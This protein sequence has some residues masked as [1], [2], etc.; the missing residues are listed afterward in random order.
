MQHQ[1]QISKHLIVINLVKGQAVSEAVSE[2]YPDCS[3]IDGNDCRGDSDGPVIDN[4]KWARETQ[5]L[6]LH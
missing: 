5:G 6:L 1:Q 2:E 4:V 3:K